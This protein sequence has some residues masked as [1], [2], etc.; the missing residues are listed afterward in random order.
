MATQVAR[1]KSFSWITGLLAG[2]AVLACF[3]RPALAAPPSQ[4]VVGCL[5]TTNG[6]LAAQSK[7]LHD[8]LEFWKDQ[9]NKKG[10]MYVKAYRKNIPVAL[11]CLNDESS[12][13]MV[14]V[15][16]NQ[17]IS[18][19][20]N[21][22][23][24]DASSLLTAS[25]VPIAEEHKM[26]LINPT[27]TSRKF[28]SSSNPYIV[29]TSDLVT[30]FWSKS[31]S[32]L[33]VHMNATEHKLNKVAIIYSTND[34]DAPQAALV[35]SILAKNRIDVVYYEGVPTTTSNYLVSI[36]RIAAAKP[37]AV[38][39]LGYGPNDIAFLRALGESG[40]H[41]NF[42]YT[43]FPGILETSFEHMDNDLAY[44]YTYVVAPSLPV[45]GI[46]TGLGV[47][48]FKRE[49]KA[50]M[51]YEPSGMFPAAGYVAGLVVQKAFELAD[52][53][54][55]LSLRKAL[56]KASGS[57]KTIGGVFKIGSDGSQE[58]TVAGIVQLVPGK[59]ALERHI[60]F[61]LALANAKPIYPA[62]AK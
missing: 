46:N 57:M 34:F 36:H 25:S 19:H 45:T 10:G 6:L 28:F 7:K 2:F 8:G 58:G 52:G 50:K 48:A 1:R 40:L 29:Q 51:G 32:D 26:L 14:G 18:D 22:L 53:T 41:F 62:P 37:D 4:I 31:V 3:M 17:L 42:V 24:A 49:F 59:M 33:L 60:V 15:L 47:E 27:G 13:S 9:V 35:K 5:Y 55:Q 43:V 38:L 61:P 56:A 11:K 39:E 12:P 54:S 44:T 20:V 21:V 16:T 30:R 23:V